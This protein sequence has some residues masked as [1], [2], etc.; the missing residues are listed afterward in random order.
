MTQARQFTSPRRAGVLALLLGASLA[1]G[2]CLN[3]T[4]L[5]DLNFVKPEGSSFNMALYQN[6]SFLAHSFGDVGAAAHKVFDYDASW[7]LNK[8]DK[9]IADLANSF[10][11]KAVMASKDE[12]IDPEPATDPASH[13]LRDRLLRALEPGREAFP[14]DAAR[15]QSDYDCWMLNSTVPAQKAAADRCRA[16]L[17]KTL[18]QLETETAAAVAAA[19]K[20]ADDAKAAREAARKQAASTG[21]DAQ[22]DGTP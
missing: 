20:A 22:A 1:L 18:P 21:G 14:R 11:S 8:T 10:A 2:G 4:P 16:S 9:S 7:S 3:A 15:A 17:D 13:E 19:E 6:Y 5:D 12:F